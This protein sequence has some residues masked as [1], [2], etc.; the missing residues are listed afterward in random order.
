MCWPRVGEANP[1]FSVC[2][3]L[4]R[5]TATARLSMPL[6]DRG[7][8]DYVL[9]RSWPNVWSYLLV[10]YCINTIIYLSI[11]TP[12]QALKALVLKILSP[13]IFFMAVRVEYHPML[14]ST[15]QKVACVDVTCTWWPDA[16]CIFVW[17]SINHRAR[18]IGC[19]AFKHF[20]HFY[21]NKN[22][23]GRNEQICLHFYR[24]FHWEAS[25]FYCT[26]IFNFFVLS[27][28]LWSWYWYSI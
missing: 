6:N 12:L 25:S 7:I 3:T 28:I 14:S 5:W 8:S 26:V 18:N 10:C 11:K 4:C 2:I 19:T 17:Y 23:Q 22:V 13:Y 24:F 9:R 16:Q 20:S 21:E 27:L 15:W 1:L